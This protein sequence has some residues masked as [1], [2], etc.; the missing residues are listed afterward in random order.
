[1]ATAPYPTI[2]RFDVW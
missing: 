2:G 1:C